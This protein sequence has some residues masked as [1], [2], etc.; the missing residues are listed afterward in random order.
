MRWAGISNRIGSD[1][2]A[3]AMLYWYRWPDAWLFPDT[4]LSS[5]TVDSLCMKFRVLKAAKWKCTDWVQWYGHDSLVL[6]QMLGSEVCIRLPCYAKVRFQVIFAGSTVNNSTQRVA[7]YP[8]TASRFSPISLPHYSRCL[9]HISIPQLSWLLSPLQLL[10]KGL[11]VVKP[12]LKSK[13]VSWYFMVEQK[14]TWLLSAYLHLLRPEDRKVQ[15]KEKTEVPKPIMQ[16]QRTPSKQLF[17]PIFAPESIF[18]S[19][20]AVPR[21]VAIFC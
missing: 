14:M 21:P 4:L 11:L 19:G 3:L 16:S 13:T 15:G 1:S 9:T 17:E 20:R 6:E 12:Q 2:G 8:A 7:V 5:E 10:T 18:C